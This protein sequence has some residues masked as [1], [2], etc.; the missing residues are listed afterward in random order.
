[1]T[2]LVKIINII[3]GVTYYIVFALCMYMYNFMS[4]ISYVTD[5]YLAVYLD[6]PV[7][8]IEENGFYGNIRYCY[9]HSYLLL[10]KF[11]GVRIYLN[12][13]IST[14]RMLWISNHRSKLDG[15]VIQSVL[16]ASKNDTI[17]VVKSSIRKIPIFGSFGRHADAIY[18]DRTN[19]RSNQNILSLGAKKSVNKNKSILIFP[20]GT[21]MSPNSKRISDAFAD[22]ENIGATKLTLIP[23]TT[24][25]NILKNDGKFDRLGNIT[26]RYDC[27]SIN[28]TDEHSYLHLL[29]LFPKKIYLDIEYSDVNGHD[30]I[31]LFSKKDAE[32]GNSIIPSDYLCEH[33]YSIPCLLFNLLIFGIFY[34]LC[35]TIPVFCCMTGIISLYSVIK[36]WFKKI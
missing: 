17:A 28:G 14:D 26:I 33:L 6:I 19:I 35:Y 3:C 18:L 4:E 12:N 13:K 11:F 10:L 20:E 1:M 8:F 24:G 23:R 15:L 22:K 27:P 21:T 30:L 7:Y 31:D 5:K 25:F 32:L 36:M 29:K 16:C 2:N 9:A 34:L